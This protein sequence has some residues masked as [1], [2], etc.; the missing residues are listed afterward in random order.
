MA[1]PRTTTAWRHWF[2]E[3]FTERLL[4]KGTAIALAVVLW[5]IASA[6]EPTE[7]VV[8][9]RFS[10]ELDSAL[11][12]R[13]P[14][15]QLRALVA[16]RGEDLLKLYTT[17]LVLT[18]QIAA[19]APDTLVI[20]LRPGD[21]AVPP[22]LEGNVIVRDVQ[23][24]RVTLYFETTSTRIVPVRSRIRLVPPSGTA[25]LRFEPES[26]EVSGPRQ[27][28]ARLTYVST[29]RTTIPSSDTLPH[30]VDVDTASLGARVRPAQV[31]VHVLQNGMVPATSSV[32]PATR[33]AVAS[34][35][36]PPEHR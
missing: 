18:R 13:D 1:I 32:P 19:D 25:Q 9:V 36:G 27:T 35:Q 2:I 23:P 15:P 29:V 17:P 21:V 6:K 34:R 26:V 31:K 4:L 12:L 22:G 20:D 16:G 14:A 7:Q 8:P 24:R 5:F 33:G 3:A 10:P 11:S 30:L 28:V